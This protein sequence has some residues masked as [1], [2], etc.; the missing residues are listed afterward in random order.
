MSTESETSPSTEIQGTIINVSFP[1][2]GHRFLREI[3]TDYFEDCLTFFES[4]SQDAVSHPGQSRSLKNANYVKTHDFD[5]VGHKVLYEDFPGSRRYLIQIRHPLESIASF[6]EF[7]LKHG[8]VRNDNKLAWRLFLAK[9]LNY[10]KRFCEVWLL[11]EQAD[12]LLITYEELCADTY[13]AAKNAIG[14]LSNSP[15]LDSDRLTRVIKKQDFLQY[16]GDTQRK[17]HGKRQLEL[18]NYF[19]LSDFRKMETALI[20]A[21]LQ[22]LG[23]KLLF[24]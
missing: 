16:V 15:S 7:S 23:I 2:S 5:L 21:Y 17:K 12:S 22:P 3:L 6:Y 11:K 8:H 4:Y 9:N 14:F 18:F 20:E 24:Q 13:Q 10:W 1:R 19:D